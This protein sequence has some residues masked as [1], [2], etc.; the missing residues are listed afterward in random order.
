MRAMG[1]AGPAPDRPSCS[2]SPPTRG[3]RGRRVTGE[4]VRIVDDK[5]GTG[6]EGVEEVE[7]PLHAEL[8]HAEDLGQ[9]NVELRDTPLVLRGRLDQRNRGAARREIAAERRQRIRIAGHVARHDFGPG[10]VLDRRG[11]LGV[12][13]Q[14][15]DAVEL[16]LRPG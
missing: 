5:G 6:V 13:G 12:T 4:S 11:D 15:Q 7:R 14:R 2:A 8:P 10:Q 1:R 9:S 3:V 16:E